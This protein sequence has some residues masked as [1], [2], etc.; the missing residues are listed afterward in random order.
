MIGG[1][2]QQL[3]TG[4]TTEYDEVWSYNVGPKVWRQM[5][6]L[7]P[8]TRGTTPLSSL[9]LEGRLLI[10]SFSKKVWELDLKTHRFGEVSPLPEEVFVDQFFWVNGRII[11]T[12]GENKLE[13]PRRRS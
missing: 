9:M 11:G 1:I 3:T 13:G 6:S 12:G 8:A 4:P 5:T 7:P 10:F 2:D